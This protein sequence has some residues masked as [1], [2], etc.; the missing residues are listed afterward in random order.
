MCE[1]C[2][3]LTSGK[4]QTCLAKEYPRVQVRPAYN[5]VIPSDPADANICD[6]CE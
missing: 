3:K 1:D 6:G 4:C 5:V 2:K